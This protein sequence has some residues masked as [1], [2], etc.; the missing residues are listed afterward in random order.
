VSTP[1]SECTECWALVSP[2]MERAHE[3]WHA[4]QNERLSVILRI[5]KHARED[6]ARLRGTLLEMEGRA[7]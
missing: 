5:A 2:G 1:W 3:E 7:P 4:K 6:A